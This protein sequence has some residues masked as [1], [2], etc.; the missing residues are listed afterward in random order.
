MSCSKDAPY[1]TEQCSINPQRVGQT[2]R[3]DVSF[4]VFGYESPALQANIQYID[5]VTTDGGSHSLQ[6][7]VNRGRT[8]YCLSGLGITPNDFDLCYGV[9]N[10]CNPV[11][12]SQE[13]ISRVNVMISTSWPSAT[14]DAKTAAP[15]FVEL[16][17]KVKSYNLPNCIGARIPVHSALHIPNWVTLLREFHDNEICHF[18]AYGWPIGFYSQTPPETVPENHPSATNFP[19][20]INQYI[21]TEI[22]HQALVGPIPAMPF[23]P[24]T[25]ISPLMTRPKRG[26]EVRRVIV[27]LSFPEGAGVNM[28]IDTSAYLGTDISYTLPTISD[29]IAKL[30]VEGQGAFIWK[31]DLARAYR[32]LRADPVDAPLL[33]I[34]FNNQIYIDRCP[35]FGCRSSSAACQRVANAI[36][37]LM[38]TNNHHCL[39][40]LDDFAGCS[41]KIATANDT[42]ISFKN[43][44]GHLG[45]QLSDHKCFKPAQ[46]VEWLGYLINTREMTVSIPEDKLKEVIAEC[47]LWFNRTR[48]NKTMVQS[49]VGRLAHIANCVLPGRKFLARMLGTLRAFGDKKWTTIDQEFIKDVKWFY[50]YASAS[51]GITLY[52]P[53][54]PYSRH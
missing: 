49:L 27:D 10:A 31:A 26:S 20:H 15:A 39:A 51:N 50:Y 7:T 17:Q 3:D 14:E 6:K 38:G 43:L 8:M 36:V 21:A 33:C 44:T 48:V 1:I 22:K 16:Y 29:L 12:V 54:A 13:V 32:Q 42:F 45:L 35:P 37:Y 41:A 24:W 18:L 5:P 23:A 40:Y 4:K 30:Q 2:T 11:T 34:K 53:P 25:R 28:G 9:L 46:T 52:A 19:S 47:A